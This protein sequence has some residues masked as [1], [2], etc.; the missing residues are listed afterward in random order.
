VEAI[1][2]ARG[3]D[4]DLVLMDIQMPKLDGI[5]A[6]KQLRGLGFERPILA[7]TAHAMTEEVER[8][9]E[10]GCNAHLTKPITKFDLISVVRQ[11]VGYPS[12]LET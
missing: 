1:S 8:S 9:I 5:Q 4:Y 2:K 7:L 12:G 3:G 6:T 11:Y 10:A